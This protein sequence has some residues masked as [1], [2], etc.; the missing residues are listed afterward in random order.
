VGIRLQ[1]VSTPTAIWYDPDETVLPAQHAEWLAS[2][3]PNAILVATNALGHGSN[4]DPK[5][6]WHRL[7]AWLI[8]HE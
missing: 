3:I 4:G 6:D 7:Y 2:V 8:A 5:P 1:R